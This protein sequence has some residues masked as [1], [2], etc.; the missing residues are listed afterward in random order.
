[1][2]VSGEV[3][4]FSAKVRRLPRYVDENLCTAC[5]TCTD[6]CPVPIPDSFNEGLCSTKALHMDYQQAI[7]AAFH[8]DEKACRYLT[9]KECRQCERACSAK[10]IDFRQTPQEIDL[11]VGAV[12][13]AP[14]FGRIAKDVLSRY[15]YGRSPDVVT[16]VEFERLTSAAGPT[17]GEIVRPS[18]G[19]H[20][21]K[22]AFLQCIGSRDLPSGNGY[23][24]SVC[25]MYAIKEA[26][27]AKEHDPNLEVVL[28]YMDMRT[29]GKEFDYARL[30]AQEKGIRF[31]R[32]RF[33][34]IQA[35]DTGLEIKYVCEEGKHLKEKFDLVVLPEG[36]ESP[37][38]SGCLADAARVD[39]NRYDF[40]RTDLF[41]PLETSRPGIYVAGAFQ[42]PKDVPESVTDASGAAALASEALFKARNSHIEVKTYPVETE[43]EEE[44]RIGVFVCFCGSNIG[45]VVDVPEVAAYAATLENVVFTDTNLYSCAQ[46][47]QELIGAKIGENRL[48]RVVVAACSPRTHEPLFQETLKSASLNRSLFEMANIRDHCSWVHAMTP[49]EATQKS[50]DLVRM[51]V[52]KARLI[53]PLP[54]QSVSVDPKAMVIGGGIS[55]MTA[56]LSIAEQGFECFLVEKGPE[57]GGNLKKVRFTLEGG[58]PATLLESTKAKV[59]SNDLIHVLTEA[60]VEDVSGYI[61]HFTTTL[62][63]GEKRETLQHGVIVVATGGEPYTPTQYLYGRSAQVITQ[64]ELEERLADPGSMKNFKDIVMIQ[65][66]GSR[67]EDLSYCSKICC[68]QAVKN[69]LEVLEHNPSANITVLY[70]DMRTYGFMEDGYS[71]AREKGVNFVRFEKGSPPRVTE[72]KGKV[73]IDYHDR[74]LGENVSLHPDLIVLSVG[75]VSHGVEDLA[76]VLKVP[77]TG[78]GFFLEAH[79][80]LRPVEFSVDGI[81][82]CGIA[83]SP[84]PIPESIAQAK[85]AACKACIPLAK[86]HGAVSGIVSSVNR[87]ICIG[88][89]ICETLCPYAAIRT[90]K[91]GKKK[92]AETISASCKGCGI[93]ASHCPTMAISMGGFSNEQIMAQIRACGQGN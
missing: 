42:G 29:Q 62:R 72:E 74:L 84:K 3:G 2:S 14:G 68:G 32:S 45:G 33:G 85:A 5:G 20:P 37:E 26:L 10:A 50:K 66:V 64:L 55:G 27:V 79:P 60:A 90:I 24:S 63:R 11:N 57:L 30:R 46:N 91:V 16:G 13:L 4:N 83:H 77:V 12:I 80:K 19:A 87:E 59:I 7:P 53:Q 73:R 36:L 56:A 35:A 39:L 40:C 25:C 86:G 76:R 47:T 31:V 41:R 15:G 69:G 78:D 28:F 67:G 51:A 89:G 93:C 92:K 75:V 22:I 1:M 43:I 71:A 82:P 6:Y 58:N 48:N 54:E 49:K 9:K 38:D 88:C 44:V 70:R 34:K 65:C 23:C 18:D 17:M 61:G 21:K 8:V 81:Y 52:A